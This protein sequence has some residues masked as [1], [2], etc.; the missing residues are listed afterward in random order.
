[1][2]KENDIEMFMRYLEEQKILS[3]S[4]FRPKYSKNYN[5]ILVQYRTKDNKRILIH[6]APF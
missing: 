4:T 3:L 6:G 2:K 1:M 5:S